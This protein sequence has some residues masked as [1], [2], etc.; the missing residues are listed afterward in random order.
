MI[1]FSLHQKVFDKEERD[2]IVNDKAEVCDVLVFSSPFDPKNDRDRMGLDVL[3]CKDGLSARV[4]ESLER[5]GFQCFENEELAK[6]EAVYTAISFPSKC[7]AEDIES[8]IAAECPDRKE[9]K[10]V[11]KT[12][13]KALLA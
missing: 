3:I 13:E 10:N 8:L 5:S 2:G 6:E 11:I 12:K 7:R 4:M 9:T 1:I